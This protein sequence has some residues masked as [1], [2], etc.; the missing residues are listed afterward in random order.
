MPLPTSLDID[1]LLILEIIGNQP[2]IRARYI[3][4][5]QTFS[6]SKTRR[7]LQNLEDLQLLEKVATTQGNA[8]YPSSTWTV[9]EVVALKNEQLSANFVPEAEWIPLTRIFANFLEQQGNLLL[10]YSDK[11]RQLLDK[12]DLQ[13]RDRK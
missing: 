5:A 10:D 11:I 1:D 12:G 13:S 9:E 7:R 3:E 4:R 8:F 6:R 2:G